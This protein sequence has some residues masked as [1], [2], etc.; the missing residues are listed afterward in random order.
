MHS[1][2]QQTP[3]FA[4]HG[5][6]LKFDIQSVHRVMNPIIE[7]QAMWLMDVRPQLISNLE[8]I[9]RRYKENINEHR[10]EQTNFKFKD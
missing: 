1:L 7:D 10:R 6:H 8:E 5:L 9:Q 4:N 3:F 2:T